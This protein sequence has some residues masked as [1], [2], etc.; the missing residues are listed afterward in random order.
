MSRPNNHAINFLLLSHRFF[1]DSTEQSV[2]K[3]D[4]DRLRLAVIRQRSLAQLSPNAALLVA[5]EWKSVMQHV[6]LVHPDG[7]GPQGVADPDGGVEAGCVDGGGETVGCGVAEMDG[8]FFRLELGDGA[9]GT[10][11]LFLHY[12]HVFGDAGEDSRLDEVALFAVALATDLE[13]GALFLT[14]INVSVFAL[15]Y[16]RV[17]NGRR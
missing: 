8:V 3:T 12:L 17:A 6:V 15:V 10:K 4:R 16:V 7:S 5:T 2:A 1:A 14:G 13:F 11:D 9:D